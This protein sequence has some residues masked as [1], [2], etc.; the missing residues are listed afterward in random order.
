LDFTE[1]R[2]ANLSR[3]FAQSLHG[4]RDWVLFL[5]VKLGPRTA[6]Y[7]TLPLSTAMN[8]TIR[9]TLLLIELLGKV[10]PQSFQ[11]PFVNFMPDIDPGNEIEDRLRAQKWC[12]WSFRVLMNKCGPSVAT[13]ATLL[14]P[15]EDSFVSHGGCSRDG[16]VAYN[17]DVP[18]YEPRHLIEGCSCEKIGP[19][20]EEVY[21]ALEDGTFPLLDGDA[22]LN[23]EPEGTL[24]MKPYAPGTEFVAFSHVWSDGLVTEKGLL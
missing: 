19:T 17:V 2:K 7:N 18:S 20:V 24:V 11:D 13:Y 1:E 8:A 15:S 14:E 10:T 23:A 4:A 6:E 22:M 3:C 5:A 9:T 12:P 16:C 21:E